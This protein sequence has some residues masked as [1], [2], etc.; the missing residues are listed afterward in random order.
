M[1]NNEETLDVEASEAARVKRDEKRKRLAA[2]FLDAQDRFIADPANS[3]LRAVRDT[4]GVIVALDSVEEIERLEVIAD[5][6]SRA[7]ERLKELHQEEVA[8]CNARVKEVYGLRCALDD[9]VAM[10]D[11]MVGKVRHVAALNDSVDYWREL[12]ERIDAATTEERK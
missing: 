9:L 3:E 12:R 11:V 5:V 8:R 2:T 7:L 6:S 4:L 10:L 1:S